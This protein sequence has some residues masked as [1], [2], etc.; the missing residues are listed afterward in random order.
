ML[1]ELLHLPEIWYCLTCKRC[2][3]VCPMEVKPS[4]LIMYARKEA[5]SRSVI[6][7]E[8]VRKFRE[9]FGQFQRVRWHMATQCRTNIDILALE[10]NW[11][12]WFE[13]SGA[14]RKEKMVPID[15]S[16]RKET[17]KETDKD[18]RA[19]ACLT[20][21]ECSNSC[22]VCYEREVFDPV[23]I[24]R[25]SHL[26]MLEELLNSPSIW[27]CIDCQRCTDTCSQL[28]KGHSIIQRLRERAVKEGYLDTAFLLRWHDAGKA[29]YPQLIK[30]I[31]ELFGYVPRESVA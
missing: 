9:L 6:E 16:S 18:A 8:T 11:Q 14:A 30:K 19:S 10:D 22:P 15:F 23:C 17:L 2:N 5:I 13:T 21:C 12:E 25:M 24:F 29:L 28:V 3:Y 31:D 26:G 20:C 1:D 7:Y 4:D 27:L